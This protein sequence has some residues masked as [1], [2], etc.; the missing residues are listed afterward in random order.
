MFQIR[1]SKYCAPTPTLSSVLSCSPAHPHLNM[2]PITRRRS[3]T[4]SDTS[5]HAE[6]NQIAPNINEVAVVTE[7]CVKSQRNVRPKTFHVSNNAGSSDQT[8]AMH[9]VCIFISFHLPIASSTSWQHA[10]PHGVSTRPPHLYGESN[11]TRFLQVQFL[12]SPR[13]QRRTTV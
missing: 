11:D 10:V 6:L 4:Q 5:K 9:S 13:K 7:I 3:T 12:Q 1:N 2:A 8:G